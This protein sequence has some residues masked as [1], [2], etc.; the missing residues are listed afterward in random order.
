MLWRG[1]SSYTET[2]VKDTPEALRQLEQKCEY[3]GYDENIV[4]IDAQGKM[5]PLNVGETTVTAKYMGFEATI[6]VVVLRL[7]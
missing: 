5:M 3:S 2:T 6:K 1:C 4:K 7:K